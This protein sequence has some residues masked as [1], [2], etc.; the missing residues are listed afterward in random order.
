MKTL[1][2]DYKGKKI[3]YSDY[4]N[5][6][7]KEMI[8]VLKN[9]EKMLSSIKK[10]NLLLANYNDS[11]PVGDYIFY[12]KEVGK[13]VLKDLTYK[14]ALVGITG[15]KR[16]IFSNYLSYTGDYNIRVFDDEK[17]ALEWLVSDYF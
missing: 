11:H 14:T 12:L 2:L 6:Q 5:C 9:K 7:S 3:L 1:W 15:S 16:L 8:Q 10:E 17:T 13:K 4:R